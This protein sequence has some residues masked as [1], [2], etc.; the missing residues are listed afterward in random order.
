MG[1]LMQIGT[2]TC[3]GTGYEFRAI[4]FLGVHSHALSSKRVCFMGKMPKKTLGRF[5]LR[6]W[7]VQGSAWIWA[8]RRT[9]DWEKG[10]VDLRS[11][12]MIAYMVKS[13]TTNI[14]RIYRLAR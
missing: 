4:V 12:I 1:R 7:T 6:I 3:P 9:D 8:S 5:E 10:V 13:Q 2:Q 11:R 14:E